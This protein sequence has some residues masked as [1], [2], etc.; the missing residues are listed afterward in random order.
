[1]STETFILLLL[2]LVIAVYATLAI[3]A[4]FRMRGKRVVVCPET[5]QP[6]A[7]TVDAAHSA[8]TAVWEKPDIQLATCSRWPER[9]GCNQ[10]CAPQ[11]AV[12]P[13]ETLATNMLKRWFAG[14]SCAMCQ[15]GIPPVHPGEP[16][17]GLMNVAS[18]THETLSWDEIPTEQLPAVLETH[19]PVCASCHVAESFRRQFPDLVVDRPG[20]EVVGGNVNVH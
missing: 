14:K 20:H 9:E 4:Y 1:M 3:A 11:I 2:A 8:A 7:V 10:A 18:P 17:P 16:K 12:A 6:A 5:N 15:R 19:L 13:E